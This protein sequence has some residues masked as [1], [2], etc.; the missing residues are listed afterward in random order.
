MD[1]NELLYCLPPLFKNWKK[2]P[3]L[4]EVEG[5]YFLFY[6]LLQERSINDNKNNDMLMSSL[7]L[8]CGRKGIL[9]LAHGIL[10]RK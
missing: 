6:F 8:M 3:I 4:P 1:N 5:G 2:Y 9:N 7:S 10:M